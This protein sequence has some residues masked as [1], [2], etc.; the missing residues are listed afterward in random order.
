MGCVATSPSS[1]SS[2]RRV[3]PRRKW[4]TQTEVSTRITG[5]PETAAAGNG[6]Q[7]GCGAT[8]CGQHAGTFARD[9]LPEA[10]MDELSLLLDSG[11]LT[12]LLDQAIVQ[13]KRRS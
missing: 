11:E 1:S 12:V 7:P 6:T 4:S 5:A 13:I 9:Q 3:L 2:L 10:A 8:Q